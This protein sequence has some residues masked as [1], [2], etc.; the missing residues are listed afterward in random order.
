MTLANVGPSHMAPSSLLYDDGVML[1][2]QDL[3]AIPLEK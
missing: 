1:S 3:A 2:L